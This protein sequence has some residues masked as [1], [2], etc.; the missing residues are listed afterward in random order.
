LEKL[1]ESSQ[2]DYI[3]PFCTTNQSTADR[4]SKAVRS[5]E[6]AQ[7]KSPEL[8]IKVPTSSDICI[9]VSEVK[10]SYPRNRPWRPIGL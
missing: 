2:T 3:V 4:E 9:H 10:Q 6:T 8:C 7:L 5:N 1:S